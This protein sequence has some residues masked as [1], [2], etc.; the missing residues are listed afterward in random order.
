MSDQPGAPT[1]P[2]EP[3]QSDPVADK[4]AEL[5][6]MRDKLAAET[7]AAQQ[8]RRQTEELTQTV[9]ALTEALQQQNQEPQDE[10]ID[11]EGVDERVLQAAQKISEVQLREYDRQVGAELNELR[12]GQ[13][14]QE[15]ERVRATDEKNFDR[16]SKAMRD[17]FDKNPTMKRPGAVEELFIRMRGAHYTKLQEM[18]RAERANDPVPDPAPTAS[19]SG[20]N[21]KDDKLDTLNSEQEGVCRGLGTHPTHYFMGKYGRKPNFAEGYVESL[22]FK[23]LEESK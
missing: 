22:G 21:D 3:T 23:P 9:G 6:K 5:D 4:L 13:F 2:Q 14:S 7:E 15:W 10:P 16:M 8:A 18:D 19:L 20:G 17:Y 1:E 12:A 11:L